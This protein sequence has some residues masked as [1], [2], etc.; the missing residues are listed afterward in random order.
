MKIIKVY[1]KIYL[2]P[3]IEGGR[4]RAI[5]SGYR[6]NIGFSNGKITDASLTFDA[7]FIFPGETQNVTAS[8][9]ADSLDNGAI[10]PHTLFTIQEGNKKIGHGVVLKNRTMINRNVEIAII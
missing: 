10:K 1:T 6:P 2:Y 8:F 5:I 4:K 9:F 7:E 3:T